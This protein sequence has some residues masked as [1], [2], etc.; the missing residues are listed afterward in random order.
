[1]ES[2]LDYTQNAVMHDYRQ[3]SACKRDPRAYQMLHMFFSPDRIP[4]GLTDN[5]VAICIRLYPYRCNME[6]VYNKKEDEKLKQLLELQKTPSLPLPTFSDALFLVEAG[7]HDTVGEAEKHL[8][9]LWCI[10]EHLKMHP[11]RILPLPTELHPSTIM[12]RERFR[13]GVRLFIAQYRKMCV[14]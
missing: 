2:P 9:H 14:P 3:T 10:A 8:E 7:V 11:I 6:K 12:T 1:M 13:Q 4:V 5:E